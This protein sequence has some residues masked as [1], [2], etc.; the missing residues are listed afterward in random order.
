M[1]KSSEDQAI[2]RILS[3]FDSR[4]QESPHRTERAFCEQLKRDVKA[5]LKCKKGFK[6]NRD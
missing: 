3:I 1:L 5:V 6:E 2:C 4:A